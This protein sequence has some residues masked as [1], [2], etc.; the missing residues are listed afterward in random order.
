MVKVGH[1]YAEECFIEKT[2]VCYLV[3]SNG[4]ALGLEKKYK[5]TNHSVVPSIKEPFKTCGR[6]TPAT[7][8][9]ALPCFRGKIMPYLYYSKTCRHYFH[10]NCDIVCTHT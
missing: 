8:G 5:R 7:V 3:L 1:L 10:Y 6:D 4:Y 9:E 2:Y